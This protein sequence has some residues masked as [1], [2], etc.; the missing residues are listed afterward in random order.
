M[1]HCRLP[2]CIQPAD[3]P[4]GAEG[5]RALR[6]RR[7]H[8]CV[9]KSR[10]KRRAKIFG[11]ERGVARR[12]QEHLAADLSRP[13]ESS[14]YSCEGTASGSGC[15]GDAGQGKP[16][17]KGGGPVD[18]DNVHRSAKG[19]D[20]ALRERRAAEGRLGLI[21]PEPARAPS[22]E[23]HARGPRPPCRLPSGLGWV[24]PHRRRRR[25]GFKTMHAAYAS[26]TTVA[27]TPEAARTKRLVL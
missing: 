11:Q 3:P 15:V 17:G 23:D 27:P 19:C 12:G 6:P 7:G 8:R 1:A 9:A 10:N 14:G 18:G 21:G 22:R 4:C 20:A 25:G 24:S 13:D 5:M 16:C 26:P 2:H